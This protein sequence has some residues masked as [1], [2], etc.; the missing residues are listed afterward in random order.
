MEV[1]LL[2]IIFLLLV[3][4]VFRRP[5]SIGTIVITDNDYMYV[6]LKN[7]AMMDKIKTSKQVIFDISHE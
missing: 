7:N 2:S 1:F 5:K 4:M 3:Y 6:E